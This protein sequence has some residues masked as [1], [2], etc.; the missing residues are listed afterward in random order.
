M[1]TEQFEHLT[2]EGLTGRIEEL[3]AEYYIKRS[4]VKAGQE[5]NSAV[6][7]KLRR[8]IARGLTLV[9]APTAKKVA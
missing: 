9:A 5:K 3:R 2:G 7:K 4:A 6:L 1:E 8:T